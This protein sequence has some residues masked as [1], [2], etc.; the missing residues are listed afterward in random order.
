MIK[1]WRILMIEKK[2][3]I[4]S[5]H[6]SSIKIRQLLVNLWNSVSNKLFK[7]Q[8]LPLENVTFPL[9]RPFLDANSFWLWKFHCNWIRWYWNRI[10]YHR[11]DQIFIQG[12]SQ[13]FKVKMNLHW[14]RLIVYLS[15][16]LKTKKQNAVYDFI[17][18][19]RESSFFDFVWW[20][21]LAFNTVSFL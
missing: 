14:D 1:N 21:F 5:V 6:F 11:N 13:M 8:L 3:D 10:S 7:I 9:K 19:N 20:N 4:E 16:V 12:N 18:L 2:T 17:D 15:T